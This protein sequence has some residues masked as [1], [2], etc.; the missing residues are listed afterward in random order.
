[1]SMETE[2]TT[3]RSY[4]GRTCRE[5]NRPRRRKDLPFSPGTAFARTQGMALPAHAP[6]LSSWPQTEDTVAAALL[7]A[8]LNEPFD[9]VHAPP[10]A[11][12]ELFGNVRQLSALVPFATFRLLA[13]LSCDDRD[14]I[15]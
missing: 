12:A 1:M 11:F 10:F 8:E 5:A 9:L 4:M 15:R 6:V 13:R 7:A 2:D 14:E 3:L